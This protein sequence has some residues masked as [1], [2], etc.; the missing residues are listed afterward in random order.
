MITVQARRLSVH[1]GRI[2]W[3]TVPLDEIVFRSQRPSADTFEKKFRCASEALVY[4]NLMRSFSGVDYEIAV[5]L[6]HESFHRD[7]IWHGSCPREQGF[8]AEFAKLAEKMS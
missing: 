5:R 2:I 7:P 8:S 4:S 1:P 3:I 6:R